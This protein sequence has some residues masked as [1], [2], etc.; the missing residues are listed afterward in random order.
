MN[1]N[2]KFYNP[3]TIYF[4]SNSLKYLEKELSQVGSNILL[5]YGGGSIKKIGLYDQVVSILSKLNK[6]IIDDGGVL[7]NPTVERVNIGCQKVLANKVDFILAIGGGS[8]IDYTKAVASCAYADSDWW[9]RYYVKME[10]VTNQILKF[11]CLLTVSGTGSEMNSCSVVTNES[12]N[13]KIGR[14]FGDKLYPQF[15]IIN[16]EW[17]K[18]VPRVQLF[19]GIYDSFTHLMEQYF[20]EGEITTNDYMLEGLMRCIYENSCLLLNNIHNDSALSNLIW[21]STWALNTLFSRGRS[22][23]WMLHMFGQAIGAVTNSNHGLTLSAIS[24]PYYSDLSQNL[25]AKFKRFGLNVFGSNDGLESLAKWINDMG[26]VTNLSDLG[27]SR[28]QI[29]LIVEGTIILNNGFREWNQENIKS[30][31]QNCF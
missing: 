6:N 22:G 19:S 1:C 2:F 11:G 12:E 5:V 31:L 9:Q 25:S 23:D 17:M 14:V 10:K 3:T 30:F 29:D 13:L 4:G 8:V 7:S 20:C 21:A 28:E 15:S 16:P 26:L 27:V 18:S 24:I